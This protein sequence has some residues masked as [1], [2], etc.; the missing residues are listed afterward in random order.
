MEA[1]KACLARAVPTVRRLWCDSCTFKAL[2]TDGLKGGGGRKEVGPDLLLSPRKSQRC[3]RDPF[4]SAAPALNI[5]LCEGPGNH[6]K[7]HGLLDG[8]LMAQSVAEPG[9][10]RTARAAWLQFCFGSCPPLAL[11]ACPWAKA[12]W[13]K[14]PGAVATQNGP[15]NKGAGSSHGEFQ[16]CPPLAGLLGPVPSTIYTSR[17]STSRCNPKSPFRLAEALA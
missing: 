11:R 8:H 14:P 6:R 10:V 9:A 12:T 13:R 1:R 16:L 5:W 3:S 2:A 7:W 4:G 17:T 15:E